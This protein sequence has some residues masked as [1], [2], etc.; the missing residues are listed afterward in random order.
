M[1]A[2]SKGLLM[3]I[4]QGRHRTGQTPLARGL[5]GRGPISVHPLE[6]SFLICTVRPSISR[7]THS[8]A[9]GTPSM[10]DE[11]P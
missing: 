5:P 3:L 7:V 2:L 4:R 9:Q 1:W 8:P 6:L 10:L 11:C